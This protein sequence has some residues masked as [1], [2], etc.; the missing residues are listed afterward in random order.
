M[1]E[2]SVWTKQQRKNENISLE[3]GGS[4]GWHEIHDDD[5]RKF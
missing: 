5:D 3:C 2:K 4:F 1:R